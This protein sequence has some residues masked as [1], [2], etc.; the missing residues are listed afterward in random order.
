MCQQ[1]FELAQAGLDFARLAHVAGH[2]VER[3][4]T[5]AGD[6]ENRGIISRNFARRNE[7]LRHTLRSLVP[8]EA[9]STARSRRLRFKLL[10]PTA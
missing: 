9:A 4:Q 10:E 1:G 2:G 6:A 3:L 5:V 8:R 7:F